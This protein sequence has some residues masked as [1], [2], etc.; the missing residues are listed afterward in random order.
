LAANH[1]L[2]QDVRVMFDRHS[3]VHNFA[4]D[5]AW[6]NICLWYIYIYI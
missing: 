5:S 6:M 2:R 1:E 4:D 3:Y